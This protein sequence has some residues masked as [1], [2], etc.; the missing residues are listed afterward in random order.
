MWHHL[1]L[2]SSWSLFL[3]QTLNFLDAHGIFLQPTALIIPSFMLSTETGRG[4]EKTVSSRFFQ[5]L[6]NSKGVISG[7]L[8]CEAGEQPV[9]SFTLTAYPMIRWS[10]CQVDARWKGHL[11]NCLTMIL[12]LKKHFLKIKN[13][14]ISK[15]I[16]LD[17]ICIWRIKYQK[18]FFYVQIYAFF[19]LFSKCRTLE[20]M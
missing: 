16:N 11:S 18:K 8:R 17:L 14:D 3:K 4:K 6:K 5:Q 15:R 2:I 19:S 20:K 10:N 1:L 13:L 12:S 7:D 9:V